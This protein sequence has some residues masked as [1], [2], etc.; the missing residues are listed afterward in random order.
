MEPLRATSR[1]KISLLVA[2]LGAVSFS[3]APGMTQDPPRLG[4]GDEVSV[5]WV[6]VSV[7][8]SGRNEPVAGLDREDFE[9]LIDG[10][11]IAVESF[12]GHHAGPI[13]VLV[14]QD[15]SGSMA[16]GGSER[17]S[18]ELARA[19]LSAAT[20]GDQYALATFAGRSTTLAVSFTDDVA[21]LEAA[22][23]AW[24]PWGTTALHDA[25][26]WLPNI[27]MDR[28]HP[29]RA[30]LLLTDGADND[31]RLAAETARGIMARTE[32]PVYVLHFSGRRP[33]SRNESALGPQENELAALSR[34][35]AG[36]YLRVF[37]GEDVEEVVR[38][39]GAGL[40][41]Q[42]VLGFPVSSD[43]SSENH[44]IEVRVHGKKHHIRH[45][46]S[47]HGAAPAAALASTEPHRSNSSKGAL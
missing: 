24:M 8:V 21:L 34:A 35:T 38:S 10:R 15:T 18:R 11:G 3:T 6:L 47:Y 41:Q 14:L 1:G 28:H 22:I 13:S 40:R 31:S 30:A 5:S 26:A 7:V 19:L 4:F 23:D 17:S 29:R 43:D 12:E 46:L 42:Y 27:G 37:D 20:P 33:R 36:R 25:I 2:T 9:L 45:R 16:N 32:I 44:D 39:I